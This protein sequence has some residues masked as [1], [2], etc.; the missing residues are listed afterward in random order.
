MKQKNNYFKEF[1]PFDEKEKACLRL[2]N[3]P[4]FGFTEEEIEQIS[5]YVKDKHM[6][7]LEL[8]FPQVVADIVERSVGITILPNGLIAIVKL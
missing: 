7:Y 1:K 3:I 2:D 6:K 4:F 5:K 8:G